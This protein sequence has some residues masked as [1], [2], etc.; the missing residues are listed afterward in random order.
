M[1]KGRIEIDGKEEDGDQ[2]NESDEKRQG[3]IYLRTSEG[4]PVLRKAKGCYEIL[5]PDGTRVTVTSSDP[6][7]P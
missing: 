7:A 6:N 4:Y 3:R 1:S 5:K 2:A